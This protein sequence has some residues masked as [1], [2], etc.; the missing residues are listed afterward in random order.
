MTPIKTA[1][2]GSVSG[3]DPVAGLVS[4][5][6][7][8]RELVLKIIA[9]AEDYWNNSMTAESRSGFMCVRHETLQEQYDKVEIQSCRVPT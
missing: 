7:Q 2:L 6:R 3:A 4:L 1:S 8:L 9:L 5:S